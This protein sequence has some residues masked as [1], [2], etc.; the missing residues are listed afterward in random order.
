M[1]GS[2][3]V[4]ILT[5]ALLLSWPVCALAMVLVAQFASGVPEARTGGRRQYWIII[6]ALNE[7]KVIG[8][9]VGA[10]LAL[11]SER[12]PVRVLV[13]DDASDD[14][15][16]D[17]LRSLDHD[18]LHVIRR[19][20]PEARQG[21]GEA[22]NAG[23]RAIRT[24]TAADE[25]DSTVVGVIDGDGRAATDTVSDVVDA[26]FSDPEVGAV[27]SRVRIG[28]R[29]RLLG[30]LQ[31]LEFCCV[32]N[33][34]QCFRD[35]VDTVGL[36]GNG[37]FVRLR[38][39]IRFGP[40]PWSSC[41]VEDIELGLRLHLE[42]VRLRYSSRAVVEQQAIVDVRRLVRQRARW[43][44]GNLQC[45]RYLRKLLLSRQ[46]GSVGLVD[47]LAYL[48]SPWL[49]VPMSV[50]VLGV[51]AAVI[52]ALATGSALG[53]L[54]ATGDA[55]P[56]AVAVWVA[57]ILFPGIIWGL[58]H[59]WT[60]G[61]E[62][63]RRCLLAGVCYPFFLLIGVFATWRGLARHVA[64]RNG[65]TKTDR[66]DDMSRPAGRASL[67]PAVPASGGAPVQGLPLPEH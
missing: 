14:E 26:Y 4:P 40:S 60:I 56:L 7:A 39:L 1:S 67:V 17:V 5:L 44:Q 57:V 24:L 12:A 9:T 6:P 43:A 32:V 18:R 34:S 28:N 45:A 29:R 3:I 58:W 41:L 59:R 22:L 36:G 48:V 61:D 63:Y 51:I 66:L 16:P 50:V 54:A 55:V 21:K 30:L 42:G 8:N 19:E 20:Q 46:V 27:Q 33:A 49:T 53:G 23:Y 15:T 35:L 10:A 52:G 2:E 47:Y 25:V 38:H 64:G 62:P 37:Q 31:D 13:V 65:W 11:H